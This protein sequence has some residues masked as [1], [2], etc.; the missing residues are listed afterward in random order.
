[1]TILKKLICIASE[2]TLFLSLRGSIV[3]NDILFSQVRSLWFAETYVKGFTQRNYRLAKAITLMV[4][5][6]VEDVRFTCIT[7]DFFVHVVV[8]S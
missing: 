6:I 1:M 5:N 2:I 7:T 8:C 3:F 4:R